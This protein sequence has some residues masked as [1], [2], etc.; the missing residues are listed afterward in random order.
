MLGAAESFVACVGIGCIRRRLRLSAAVQK[1][2]AAAME[3]AMDSG[4]AAMSGASVRV[5]ALSGIAFV[6]VFLG[7][8]KARS[9]CG[10][11]FRGFF[12]SC[13]KAFVA[14]STMHINKQTSLITSAFVRFHLIYIRCRAVCMSVLFCEFTTL[15]RDV[16]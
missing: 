1:W 14:H 5:V 13:A 9:F 11:V 10:T 15:L 4:F 6:P 7:L 16:Q 3:S 8:G 12:I 2:L